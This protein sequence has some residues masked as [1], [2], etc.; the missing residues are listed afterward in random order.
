MR[1]QDR[2]RLSAALHRRIRR[3]ALKRH[4]ISAEPFTIAGRR[5]YI[6]PTALG[7]AFA[8]MVFAM[9]LGAMNYA[10]NLA[11]ALSFLL[12]ALGL[13]AM[14]HCQRNLA[15]VRLSIAG[16]DAAFAGEAARFHLALDHG[17]PLLDR[18]H[19]RL[20][21]I[22]GDPDDQPVDQV[23]GPPDDIHMAE[24]DR[25]ESARID[26]SPHAPPLGDCRCAEP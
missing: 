13:V 16:S 21:R 11:L 6:L 24:R 10:N 26:A 22:G 25:I 19:G 3:W 15:G 8:V 1:S 4:G 2:S 23:R 20:A 5:I 12:G 18:E 7:V 14:H 17:E 9:F